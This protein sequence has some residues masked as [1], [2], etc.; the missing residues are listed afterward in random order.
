MTSQPFT[1]LLPARSRGVA[2]SLRAAHA[3]LLI[4]TAL[5]WGLSAHTTASQRQGGGRGMDS[6]SAQRSAGAATMEAPR[7]R[8]D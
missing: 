7:L 8:R 4:T 6:G 1:P 3:A 2:P 5:A